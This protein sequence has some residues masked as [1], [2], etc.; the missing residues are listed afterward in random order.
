MVKELFEI[1][2]K[3]IDVILYF[4]GVAAIAYGCFLINKSAGY[5]SIGA[6]ALITALLTEILASK[7]GS[8]N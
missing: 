8:D 5:I 6:I 2:W 4:L 7:K 3:F 1:I